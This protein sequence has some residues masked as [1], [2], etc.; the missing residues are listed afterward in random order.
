MGRVW[1]VSSELICSCSWNE[2][3]FVNQPHMFAIDKSTSIRDDALTTSASCHK[4][5]PTRS[6]R[7]FLCVLF[8]VVT[9]AT[10]ILTSANETIGYPSVRVCVQIFSCVAHFAVLIVF[11]VLN[12]TICLC[13]DDWAETMVASTT[14][15]PDRVVSLKMLEMLKA[16]VSLC[17]LVTRGSRVLLVAP[18]F[19]VISLF[20]SVLEIAIDPSKDTLVDLI[21]RLL[22][23]GFL[24][25]VPLLCALRV[26][27]HV[28][29]LE[30]IA[31]HENLRDIREYLVFAPTQW[32]ITQTFPLN[33]TLFARAGSALALL[34]AFSTFYVTANQQA[35]FIPWYQPYR[36]FGTCADGVHSGLEQHIDCGNPESSCPQSCREKYGEYILIP[37]E[38][39]CEDV[40]GYVHITTQRA[41]TAAYNTWSRLNNRSASVDHAVVYEGAQT[42][43][44]GILTILQRKSY[45]RSLFRW[46]HAN[47]SGG[48]RCGAYPMPKV[49][50]GDFKLERVSFPALFSPWKTKNQQ[51]QAYLCYAAAMSCKSSGY[52]NM[53]ND[54]RFEE[55]MA[56]PGPDGH[57]R[58]P[59]AWR[60]ISG[61]VPN[62]AKEWTQKGRDNLAEFRV[63]KGRDG[64]CAQIKLS[65]SIGAGAQVIFTLSCN[66]DAHLGPNNRSESTP[67][68]SSCP[69]YYR[70]SL[71]PQ[72]G[73]VPRS[74]LVVFPTANRSNSKEY[75]LDMNTPQTIVVSSESTFILVVD[76]SSDLQGITL[77][78]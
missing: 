42:Y 34:F 49:E 5:G 60:N 68:K 33:L 55:M 70:V 62:T 28:G 67:T 66:G 54:N 35:I 64:D 9:A 76:R 40:D 63:S 59:S 43:A 3:S 71:S 15:P 29:Y 36:Q 75:A 48:F 6:N 38:R 65:N 8:C 18:A 23:V 1:F 21:D 30:Q 10:C 12:R 61:P 56:C 19:A 7:I 27:S 17:A 24:H 72:L 11:F 31:A 14:S 37:A 39:E 74:A 45:S 13:Y 50:L 51:P 4:H 57:E 78:F 58:M 77:C 32:M 16:R 44:E 20:W 41:C 22:T 47:W 52:A 25:A 26:S 2:E 53:D 73:S 69:E 46:K